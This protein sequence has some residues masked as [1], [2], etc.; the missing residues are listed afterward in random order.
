MVCHSRAANFTLGLQTAQLNRNFSYDGVE[1]NQLAF[2]ERMSFFRINPLQYSQTNTPAGNAAQRE[3]SLDTSLLPTS[4][5][6][7]PRLANPYDPQESL[8]LRA[9]A[10]LHSNCSSCH[11]PAGGGNASMDLRYQIPLAQC[12]LLEESPRHQH[13]EIPNAKIVSPG[14]PDKSVLMRRVATRENGRM[15]QLATSMIDEAAV[16]MLRKWIISLSSSDTKGGE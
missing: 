7:L 1:E 8:A 12:G 14:E 9:R 2:L 16:E 3:L 13:F 15:P 4:P 10:Y 6:Q 11:Q 5:K